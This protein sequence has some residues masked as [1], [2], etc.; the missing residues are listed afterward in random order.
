MVNTNWW[1]GL[2][3]ANRGPGSVNT[4]WGPGLLNANWDSGTRARQRTR[5]RKIQIPL[6]KPI[7]EQTARSTFIQ[8]N[9]IQSSRWFLHNFS[10]IIEV[11][12][13]CIFHS[14]VLNQPPVYY[15]SLQ[16]STL[17]KSFQKMD[18]TWNH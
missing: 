7:T 4:N 3:I 2:V 8:F 1:P 11:L 9:L 12:L 16:Y 17:W 6:L 10:F 13:K 5:G 15:T 18:N 14:I